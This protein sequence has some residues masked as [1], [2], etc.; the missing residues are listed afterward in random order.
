[1][2]NPLKRI[3]GKTIKRASAS[4]VEASD[5]CAYGTVQLDFTD[6]SSFSFR[7]RALPMIDAM[8][9]PDEDNSDDEVNL[10]KP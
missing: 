5:G 9:F 3:Q 10:V 1:V 7:L 8:F 6:G 4:R 2:K